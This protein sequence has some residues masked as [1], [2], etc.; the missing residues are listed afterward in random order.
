M[1]IFKK[2]FIKFFVNEQFL[3]KEL[4]MIRVIFGWYNAKNPLFGFNN[5]QIINATDVEPKEV[6]CF[7]DNLIELHKNNPQ[8]ETYN[9]YVGTN[10]ELVQKLTDRVNKEYISSNDIL[11]VYDNGN[12]F[13]G[14]AWDKV[15]EYIS[16]MKSDTE[17]GLI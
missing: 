1:T 3:G 4:V 17:L 14:V 9:F 6:D 15:K 8:K 7:I 5:G 12:K 13:W 16:A 10:D 11:L 2:H